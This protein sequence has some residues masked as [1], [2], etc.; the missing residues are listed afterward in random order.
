MRADKGYSGLVVARE[1]AIVIYV[2]TETQKQAEVQESLMV[3]KK[4]SSRCAL[5]GGS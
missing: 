1:S 3:G 5:S 2:L 4:E